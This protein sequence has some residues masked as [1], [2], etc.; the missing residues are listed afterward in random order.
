MTAPVT[1]LASSVRSQIITL[2]TSAGGAWGLPGVGAGR[3]PAKL[4]RAE[5]SAGLYLAYTCLTYT[6]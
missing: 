4:V 3:L 5:A 6:V 2:A 1:H